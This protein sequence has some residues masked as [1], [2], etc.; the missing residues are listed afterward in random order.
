MKTYRIE[1]VTHSKAFADF[2][3]WYEANSEDEAMAE[4]KE[5]CQVWRKFRKSVFYDPR[6]ER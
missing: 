3:N 2:C 6:S 1:T 4:Y 5:D